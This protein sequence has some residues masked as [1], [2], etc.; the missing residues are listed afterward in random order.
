MRKIMPVILSIFANAVIGGV[1]LIFL[2]AGA[3]SSNSGHVFQ[4]LLPIEIGLFV[5]I[6]F[7]A[8]FFLL[9]EK[10]LLA[11]LTPFATIPALGLGLY[12]V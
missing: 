9:C 11:A 5:F 6:C 8:L 2:A 4:K 10:P 7:L 1:F 12:L 3:G